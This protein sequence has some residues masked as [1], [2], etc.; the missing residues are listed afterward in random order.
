[1]DTAT[2]HDER[3]AQFPTRELAGFLA[4]VTYHDLP[5]EVMIH[6]KKCILDTIGCGLHGSNLPW[7]KIA[8]ET[9]QDLGSAPVASV[10][11][12][13]ERVAPADA[14][15]V[16]GTMV[17]AFEL[18]DLHK[19]AIVHPGGV[20]IPAVVAMC[21]RLPEETSGKDFIAAVVAGYEATIRVGL[22]VGLGLLHRGWHNNGILGTFGGAAGVANLL[23]LDAEGMENAIGMAASQ[24][25][26][27]MSA[28]YGSMIKRMHAGKAAQSGLYAGALAARGFTG[29]KDVMELPYGGFA[30]TFADHYNLDNLVDGLGDVWETTNVGFKFYSCCGSNHTTVDAIEQIR[31]EMPFEAPDVKSIKVL[32]STATKDHVG[33]QYKPDALTTAQMNLSYAA[34]VAVLFGK[35]FVEQFTEDLLADPGVLE[36]TNKVEVEADREIDE[37]GRAHRHE[38]LVTVTLND[39]RSAASRIPHAKGSEMNPLTEE[40]LSWK[41]RNLA[42][43][44]LP[45]EQVA[46]LHDLIMNLEK[47]D[48][49]R[50]LVGSMSLTA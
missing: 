9:V 33:W 44:A 24:S 20:T 35:V 8:L 37:K 46:K 23:R 12:T 16:N 32:G 13:L 29:I 1:M 39:G 28:Q 27:L 45:S 6:A 50:T 7:S 14:A 25:A 43:T 17:H 40:E 19:R 41:F 26:G 42:E 15:L 5:P 36:L 18:D 31:K 30:S 47:V 11:G 3:R 2:R 49:I 38:V 34:A 22:G 48:D 4:N 10:W 21:E